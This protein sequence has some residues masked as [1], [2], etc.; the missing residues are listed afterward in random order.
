MTIN[1][2]AWYRAIQRWRVADEAMRKITVDTL[3][4]D[5]GTYK[6]RIRIYGDFMELY[7]QWLKLWEAR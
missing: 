2:F 5:L 3:E 1:P 4:M 6:E 7:L